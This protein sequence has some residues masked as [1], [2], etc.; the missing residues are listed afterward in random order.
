MNDLTSLRG[1]ITSLSETMSQQQETIK[2]LSEDV[3]E[4]KN[5]T[6]SELADLQSS[7]DNPPIKMISDAV[8]L[9]LLPYLN[10]IEENLMTDLSRLINDRATSTDESVSSLR[11]DLEMNK[12]WTM[13]ELAHLQSSLQSISDRVTTIDVSVSSF[14]EENWM[15]S[16]LADLQT[17]LNSTLVSLKV[18]V[19]EELRSMKHQLVDT[20][21]DLT[22]AHNMSEEFENQVKTLIDPLCIKVVELDHNLQQNITV[23]N[24]L[25]SDRATSIDDSVR[26]LSGEFGEHKNHTVSALADLQA[27]LNSELAS[28]NSSLSEKLRS[29][30]D[31]LGAKIDEMVLSHARLSE[32]CENEETQCLIRC[33]PS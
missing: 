9:A 31:Q 2:S 6:K 25:V 28:L 10:N 13:S 19:T 4:H 27:S 33:V 5:Q 20:R 15:K 29:M 18:S 16:E 8:R 21:V 1:D 14:R 7:I 30:E 26:N 23:L 24:S 3:E 17:S 12:N 11:G 22:D 32:E